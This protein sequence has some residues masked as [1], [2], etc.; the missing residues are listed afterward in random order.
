VGW[1]AGYR[2]IGRDGVQQ[3]LQIMD[4]FPIYISIGRV[5]YDHHLA[6]KCSTP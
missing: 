1:K 3:I 5:H 2:P 4:I 6:A